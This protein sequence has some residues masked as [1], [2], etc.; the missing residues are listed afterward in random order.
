MALF[1]MARRYGINL[2]CMHVNYQKRD[3]AIR[4]EMI[5]QSYCAKY[6]IPFIKINAG[7]HSGNFQAWARDFRYDFFMKVAKRYGIY[8]VLM[9][10]QLDDYLE[11]LFMQI[12]RGSM[13]YNFGIKSYM[14][15][16]GL[17]IYRPLLKYTKSDLEN[18]CK[19][20]NIE[21]GVDESNLEDH[22]KRNRIRHQI[23]DKLSYLKKYQLYLECENIN[24]RRNEYLDKYYKTY[25]SNIYD[26]EEVLKIKDLKLFLRI[27]LFHDLSDKYL[28]ELIRQIKESKSFLIKIRDKEVSKYQNKLYFDNREDKYEFI[29]NDINDMHT[30]YFDIKDASDSFRCAYITDD[31]LPLKIRNYQEGDY[32][33]MRYGKKHISRFFIDNKI[34]LIWRKKWPI[35]ENSHSE[36]ILVPQIGPNKTHYSIKPNLFMVEYLN[37]EDYHARRR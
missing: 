10:H 6:Q 34:P 31:D 12:K 33:E 29:I 20:N 36:I 21:Y 32:I 17:N 27:K 14:E 7:T 5:V 37:T 22:Y 2:V 4:D 1:D 13:P 3:T 9:A 16:Y 28:N 24:K 25:I 11:T 26:L 23:I 15:E 35:V 30:D 18:Y 8:D 19:V